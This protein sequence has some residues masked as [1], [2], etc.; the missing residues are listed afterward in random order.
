MCAQWLSAVDGQLDLKMKQ[1]MGERELGARHGIEGYPH[2]VRSMLERERTT[3]SG[4]G[5]ASKAALFLWSAEWAG[6][7]PRPGRGQIQWLREQTFGLYLPSA[8]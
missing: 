2:G 8:H 3:P 6:R 5:A 1:A 4:L 7:D